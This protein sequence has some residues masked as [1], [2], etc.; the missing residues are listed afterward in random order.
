MV[1][2][3]LPTSCRSTAS[4]AM[5]L[6]EPP[7]RKEKQGGAGKHLQ[8]RGCWKCACLQEQRFSPLV[9]LVSS[10]T[11]TG[12]NR[13]Q[14]PIRLLTAAP[15]GPSAAELWSGSDESD[16][17]NEGRPWPITKPQALPSEQH[18]WAP[19][20]PIRGHPSRE[21]VQA[22]DSARLGTREAARGTP[23]SRCHIPIQHFSI[24]SD[25]CPG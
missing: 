21:A 10:D 15:A 8:H 25:L 3:A 24:H 5:L 16:K 11:A 22:L 23:L 19:S 1:V 12:V 2:T 6:Q 13:W 9:S 20:P 17:S 7:E 14:V 18:L 4:L